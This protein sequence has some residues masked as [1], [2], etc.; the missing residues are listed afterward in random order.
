M[1]TFRFGDFELDAA[2]YEL[3]SNGRP[4]R[5]ERL[6]M[7]ALIRLVSA[8]G[9]LVTRQELRAAL[10]PADVFMDEESAVNTVVRKVRRTLRDSADAPQYVQTVIGKGYRFVA[11]VD[12]SPSPDGQQV[13]SEPQAPA[14]SAH[15]AA[16]DRA[17]PGR[18][19]RLAVGAVAAVFVSALV[20]GA[21]VWSTPSEGT[22]A[23]ARHA[24][25]GT[26]ARSVAPAAH[27]AYVRGRYFWNKR[28]EA[29]LRR[30]LRFFQSSL[31]A[32]PTYAPAYVGLSDAYAQLGYGSYV[33]PDEAFPLAREAA[34]RAIA[35][36]PAD[37]DAHA[38]L[39]YALMY[40]DWD[41]AGA[42][43]ELQRAVALAPEQPLAH[44]WRAYLLTAMGRPAAEAEREIAEARRLDPLS[45]AID[46]DRAY[47]LHYYGRNDEA[48]DAARVALEMNPGFPLAQFWRGRIYT[49]QRRYGEAKAALE[50]IGPLRSWTP[51][52]AALGY[53]EARAGDRE[54]ARHVL[55][56]FDALGRAGRY[57]SSYA[58]A[59]IYAGLGERDAVF[60]RLDDALRER[61]HWLVWLQRDPRWNDVR[62]DPRFANLVRRVGLP[63]R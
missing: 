35:L 23:D 51:A 18:I 5:V 16:A 20:V 63:A 59:V 9:A 33:R 6:P 10:W 50:S 43:A 36:E 14:F 1:S 54:A 22:A 31:D 26:G 62:D 13:G 44:Q 41:F 11:A 27:D 56:E 52:M 47:I 46:T 42:D 2:A 38:A 7:E 55:E 12:A 49:E 4:V 60:A 21:R 8:K 37:A 15:R 40:Y 24:K 58:I 3:K 48:L 29:D 17:F 53:L 34:R 30:A 45:V 28:T 25:S 32:D 61:S 57:T 19:A 39:G